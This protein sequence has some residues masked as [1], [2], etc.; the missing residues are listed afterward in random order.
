VNFTEL[1][2]QGDLL[3]QRFK[4]SLTARSQQRAEHDDGEHKI[5]F[6]TSIHFISQ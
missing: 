3:I 2:D 4:D 6:A 5:R 1:T